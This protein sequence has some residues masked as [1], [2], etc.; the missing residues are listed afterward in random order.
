MPTL[1][2]RK[3]RALEQEIDITLAETCD[4]IEFGG[5]PN[6]V[7]KFQ[8]NL[9]SCPS[10]NSLRSDSRES[11]RS[12]KSDSVCEKLNQMIAKQENKTVENKSTALHESLNEKQTVQ[13]T[14]DQK[15]I[16]RYFFT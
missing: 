11:I 2:V 7:D 12:T 6:H 1:F 8:T 4:N 15:F 16:K 9:Q 13:K 5:S 3:Q 14:K 10:F